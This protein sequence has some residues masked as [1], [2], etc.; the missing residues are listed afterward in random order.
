MRQLRLFTGAELTPPMRDHTRAR[1]CSPER[2]T[3]R[4]DHR[5]LRYGGLKQCRAPGSVAAAGAFCRERCA[6]LRESSTSAASA[7]PPRPPERDPGPPAAPKTVAACG[8]APHES[9]GDDAKQAAAEQVAA[10]KVGP[11]G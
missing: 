10:V 1:N 11:T 7:P 6:Q 4:C 2:E 5:E 3:F 9:S 8:P